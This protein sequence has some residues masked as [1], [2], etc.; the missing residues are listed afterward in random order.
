VVTNPNGGGTA[1]LT[2]GFTY[3]GGTTGGGKITGKVTKEDT[4][5]VLSGA[6]VSYSGGSTTTN[7]S[8]VYTLS[9]VPAGS[10][11]VKVAKS[12]YQTLSKTVTVSSGA[13]STLNFALLPTCTISTTSLTV[14]I[15][16]PT[17]NSTV[18]NSVH[19]IAKATDTQP[20]SY[21]QIYVDGVKKYQIS[22]SSIN[23]HVSMST[24]Q[25]RLTVQA[26]D[27]Q[28]RIFRHTIYITVK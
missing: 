23:T 20:V 17:S 7:S 13:T 22:G 6:T 26:T 16:L 27:S 12:G 2:G 15:C 11:S 3:T 18:L 28:N 9:N 24:G 10:T 5:V 25:R 4:T 14:T 19:V 8:E 1:T 21:T